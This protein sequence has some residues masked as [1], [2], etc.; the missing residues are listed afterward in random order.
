MSGQPSGAIW[1]YDIPIDDDAHAYDIPDGAAIV[2]AGTTAL[3]PTNCVSFWAFVLPG[4]AR[5]S[6]S[7]RIVGTGHPINYG[8]TYCRTVSHPDQVLVWHLIEVTP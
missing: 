2:H 6:R 5:V 1:K 4:N 3:T 8:E 7:F